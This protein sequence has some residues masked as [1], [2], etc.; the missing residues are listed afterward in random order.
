MARTSIDGAQSP[1]GEDSHPEHEPATIG[2]VTHSEVSVPLALDRARG[3]SEPSPYLRFTAEEW[4]RL[5]AA[6]PLTLNETD[7]ERLRGINVALSLSD[8]AEIMLPLSRLLNLYV[9]AS[10]ELYRASDTFL[11]KLPGK[12]PYIIGVAG[13]VA[14]GKSTTARVLQALLDRWPAHPKVDLITTDGFLYPN[15]VLV[16]RN[17][18][19]RKGFPE[20][21]DRRR[22]LRFLTDIKS[23]MEEV[24]A[25]VYSH[26]TYDITDDVN[27]VRQPDIVIVEGLNVLQTGAADEG[28]PVF[29]SDFFDFSIYVDA[30][31]EDIRLWYIERFVTLRETAFR[32][33]DSYFHRY[34]GLSDQ[35]AVETATGI[36][37]SINQKN[38]VE[39][40]LPTR[41][42][43]DLILHK[44]HDHHVTE[45]LLRRL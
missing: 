17:L 35:E 31:V 20:S 29:V 45:V 28:H 27:I 38:L 16:E 19:H 4:G 7:L 12:V 41:Q 22:L 24:S 33:P 36:W 42:R 30:D 32:D 11:G 44:G 6:T 2:A 43:A 13:S 23:G 8:V 1:T 39:N 18:M 25:P 9:G 34:A 21:Y 40:I 5:R 15:S 10:Q 14:V 26:L 37:E 3:N